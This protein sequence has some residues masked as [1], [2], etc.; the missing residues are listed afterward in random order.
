MLYVWVWEG[1]QSHFCNLIKMIGTEE[2]SNH[3]F[4]SALLTVDA[5][6]KFPSV[7]GT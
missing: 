7:L 5:V 2:M 3:D 6:E 1:S 4:I